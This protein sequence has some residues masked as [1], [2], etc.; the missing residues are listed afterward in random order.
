MATAVCESIKA[1]YPDRKLIVISAWPEVFLHNPNIYR[2][3]KSGNFAYFYEDFIKDKDSIV[4]RLE[5]YHSHDF[6][7]QTKSL[8][9]IWC[10]LFKIPCITHQPQ[11]FLTQREIVNAQSVINCKEPILL[12]H[13]FGGGDNSENSYSW[14]RDLPPAF[15]Q[16]L[17]NK[18][19]K[20]FGKILQIRK[21]N[22]LSLE[23][24]VSVTDNLRN[25]FCYVY[26]SDKIIAID[27]MIQHI[28]A[29]LNKKTAVGWIANSP[30]V[31]GYES[32]VNIPAQQRPAFR[33][34]IDS[35]LEELDWT[36]KRFYECPYDDINNIFSEK[37][38]IEYINI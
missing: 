34:F 3:Y 38:F 4:F 35:Y 20:K 13:P 29:A 16:K 18:L 9:E 27:S 17:V 36:G 15:A 7:Y 10:D 14:A 24:T 1:A 21:E 23:N 26:L 31:F 12:I 28:A 6:I 32:H 30:K 5:P 33:H 2:I 22:Q 8:I 19:S 25:I 37:E 11:I